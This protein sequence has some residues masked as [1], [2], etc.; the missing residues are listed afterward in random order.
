MFRKAAV[1]MQLG[2]Q[3]P[4]GCVQNAHGVDHLLDFTGMILEVSRDLT[5]VIRMLYRN[6]D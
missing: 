3:M 2:A 6:P 5:S 4:I 1:V